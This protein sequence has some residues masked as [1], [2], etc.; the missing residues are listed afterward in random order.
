[1]K[2]NFNSF[3]YIKNIKEKSIAMIVLEASLLSNIKDKVILNKIIKK[4]NKDEE[5]VAFYTKHKFWKYVNFSKL[6]NKKL[7]Q[8]VMTI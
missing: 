4:F 6:K 8:Y 3:I 1:M 2:N 7:S 5:I